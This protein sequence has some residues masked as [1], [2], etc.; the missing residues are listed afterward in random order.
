MFELRTERLTC[1][2]GTAA[3]VEAIHA[4][5]S[6]WD[7]VKNLGSWPYPADLSYT[8]NRIVNQP[9]RNSGFAGTVRVG[10][11]IVGGMG[12]VG[13]SGLCVWPRLLGEGLCDRDEQAAC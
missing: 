3:D 2:H 13:G 1:R 5:V 11:V 7:V 6:D 4:I 10:D 9:D 12:I 8:I